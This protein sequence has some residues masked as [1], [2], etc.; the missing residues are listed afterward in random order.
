MPKAHRWFAA[1]YDPLMRRANPQLDRLRAQVCGAARGRVLEIGFGTGASL[2][3][4]DWQALECLAAAEPDPYMLSR[5]AAKLGPEQSGK[6]VLAQ[7]AAESLPFPNQSF[8]TVV[9][10]LVLCTVDDQSKA[11]SEVRRVMK[12]DA[13]LRLLEHVRGG[14]WL[15]KG[16]D[17][18]EPVWG[19]FS[20]GC[21]PNRKTEELVRSAGFDLQTE[22]RLR[23]AIGMP[24]FAG[25]ARLS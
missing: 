24:A 25:V 9:S 19:W 10:L 11:L 14:E 5:A 4:Y 18:I 15:G 12:P 17:L 20:G 23:L 13:S 21:H 7:A 22:R 8:D 1:A 3:F 6:V 2:E 16:Q